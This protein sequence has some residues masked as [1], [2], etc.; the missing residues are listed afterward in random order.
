[1]RWSNGLTALMDHGAWT[2][3]GVNI[4]QLR[5]SAQGL[6]RSLQDD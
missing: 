2:L 5:V 4:C 1:M 6:L 3:T